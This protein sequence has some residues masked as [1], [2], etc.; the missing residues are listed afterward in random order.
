MDEASLTSKLLE[1]I[2]LLIQKIL[3]AIARLVTQ[4]VLVTLQGTGV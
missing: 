1:A 4:L 3:Q 2:R